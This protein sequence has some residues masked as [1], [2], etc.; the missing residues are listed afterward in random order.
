MIF[1]NQDPI[2]V[3]SINNEEVRASQLEKIKRVRA[4]RDE[5]KA[6]AALQAL[7]EVAAKLGEGINNSVADQ[8]LVTC[9]IRGNKIARSIMRWLESHQRRHCWALKLHHS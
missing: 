7:N 2:D 9:N 3:L 1:F 6:A 4:N 8:N 5:A